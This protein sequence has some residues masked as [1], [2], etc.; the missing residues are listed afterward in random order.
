MIYGKGLK[1]T[2]DPRYDEFERLVIDEK[3]LP[4]VLPAVLDY[5]ESGFF[6]AIDN[7]GGL[8]TCVAYGS[9]KLFE[10]YHA[11]RKGDRELVSARAIYSY[12]KSTYEQGDTQDDGLNVSDGLNTI[13]TFYVNESDWPSVPNDSEENFPAYL[14][15]VPTDIRKTDF[16]IKSFATVNPDVEDMKKALYKKGI[17]LLGI[18]FA[19]EWMNTGSDGVLPIPQSVDGGHCMSIVGWN[20]NIVCPDGTKGAFKIA[21]NWTTDWGA[22]GYCYLPYSYQTLAG[23][24]FWPTDLFTVVA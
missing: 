5:S 3:D 8:G 24:Q 23:G 20:D 12:A 21:N 6:P 17:M 15:P 13:A 4:P 7:Q 10:F 19:N 18:A 1:S 2:H 11:K 16:I 14:I 9:R 22:A